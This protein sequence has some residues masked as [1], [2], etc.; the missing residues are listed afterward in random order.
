[1]QEKERQ[2]QV[3]EKA[4][5]KVQLASEISEAN[6][7]LLLE[8][9]RNEPTKARQIA[10]SSPE[11]LSLLLPSSGVFPCSGKLLAPLLNF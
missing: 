8:W 9:I 5:L 3:Q 4:T 11:H 7:R 6:K 1:V 10:I 2:R